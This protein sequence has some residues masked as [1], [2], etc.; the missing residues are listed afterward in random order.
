MALRS[1]EKGFRRQV[2]MARHT[3]AA[4]QARARILRRLKGLL[5]EGRLAD[6]R[7]VHRRRMAERKRR[8]DAAQMK[9]VRDH[10]AMLARRRAKQE[11]RKGAR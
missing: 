6:Q 2:E 9:R 3:R 8:L 5:R 11:A 4:S 10:R 1:L 7:V